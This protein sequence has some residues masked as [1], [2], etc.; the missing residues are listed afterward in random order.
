MGKDQGE[1]YTGN[2]VKCLKMALFV[3]NPVYPKSP[4]LFYNLL[5]HVQEVV[6]L[7]SNLL[8]KIVNYFLCI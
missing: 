2:G 5:L 7:Y 4:S 3:L 1:N 8:Y 6:S